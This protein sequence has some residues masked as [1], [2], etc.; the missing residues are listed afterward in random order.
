MRYGPFGVDRRI[1]QILIKN[2]I[3]ITTELLE[4][5]CDVGGPTV[6]FRI[7]TVEAGKI[8]VGG[9]KHLGLAEV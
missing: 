8:A 7:I 3:E 9:D 4:N 5:L 6:S 1:G 2:R